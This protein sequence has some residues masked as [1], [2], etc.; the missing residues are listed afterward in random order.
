MKKI[1]PEVI[2]K[3][4]VEANEY[5]TLDSITGKPLKAAVKAIY[6]HYTV[7]RKALINTMDRIYLSE[8]ALTIFA[9]SYAEDI[10]YVS[11]SDYGAIARLTWNRLWDTL[12]KDFGDKICPTDDEK[13]DAELIAR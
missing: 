8:T 5:S 3:A 6:N 9:E 13:M 4:I 11:E 10:K 1:T 12:I 2:R 7:I